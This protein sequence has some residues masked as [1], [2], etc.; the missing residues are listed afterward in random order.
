MPTLSPEE[1]AA[2]EALVPDWVENR[3]DLVLF[4][5]SLKRTSPEAWSLF[6]SMEWVQDG[7]GSSSSGR[8]LREVN[9]ASQLRHMWQLGLS[10]QELF[11]TVLRKPWL[12]D[13]LSTSET[14][15]L[16]YITYASKADPDLVLSLVQMPFLD[17]VRSDLEPRIS[18]L[19]S[20]MLYRDSA[21]LH[22]LLSNED[23]TYGIADDHITTLEL[24]NFEH[25]EPQAAASIR[26]LA[27]VQDGTDASEWD[28][29]VALTRLAVVSSEVLG[30]VLDKPW[31]QDGL[32]SD[33][34]S[35][36][37]SLTAALHFPT[38]GQQMEAE[39]LRLLEM[40]FLD[41]VDGKDAA[42]VSVLVFSL[43]SPEHQPLALVQSYPIL[44][45]G[46]T[47]DEAIIIAVLSIVDLRRR[48]GLL[49][50]LLDPD[51]TSTARRV[52]SL[53]LAGETTLVVVSVVGR[54]AGSLDMLE[55]VVRAQEEFMSVPFPSSWAALLVAD[56]TRNAGQALVEWG[57]ISVDPGHQ[58]SYGVLAHETAHFYWTHALTTWLNE[59][60]AE[61]MM[62]VT[63][64]AL[65]G[66]RVEPYHASC[67][68]APNLASLDRVAADLVQSNPENAWEI[69]YRSGCMYSLGRGLFWELYQELGQDTFR[70]AFASLYAKV[71]DQEHYDRCTGLERGVCYV[72][73]AFVEDA[74]P[75]AA[76]IA[77]AIIDK[78]YNGSP[79]VRR[80]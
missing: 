22:S 62:M 9:A 59:G 57:V 67:S 18:Y 80:N 8:V 58:A 76:A 39:V 14:N 40:P 70:T 12:R 37:R 42:A 79:P 17:T 75:E 13:E 45:D 63:L 10:G 68:L 73:A 51:R 65:A 3:S 74:Q 41:T 47:D 61:L 11:L 2:V 1:V 44:R 21:A 33:E 32:S 49:E 34:T 69:I 53:P 19:V 71:L 72:R 36:I 29:T 48:S 50:V 4:L 5:L 20:L 30:S 52:I 66:E 54:E 26:E 6:E 7:I 43:Q 60:P 24:I 28:G 16:I 78:W 56:A 27:W 35:T 31:T 15:V 64:E 25:F 55:L 38:S 23:F 77:G 46:I